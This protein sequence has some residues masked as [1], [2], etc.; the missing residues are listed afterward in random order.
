MDRYNTMVNGVRNMI[1][2][3]YVSGQD[4]LRSA[5]GRAKVA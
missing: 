1:N 2:D 4:P 5:I 3:L